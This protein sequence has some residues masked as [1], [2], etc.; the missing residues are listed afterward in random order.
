LIRRYAAEFLGTFAIVFFGCGAIATLSG[1]GSA[2][3]LAINTVFGLTVAAA[4]Y[5]LGHISAAHF[6]PA[7]TI[8]FAVAKRFPW[9]YVPPYLVAQLLGALTGSAIHFALL[10]DKAAN[11]NFGATLPSIDAVRAVGIEALL[12]L[13]L[14]LVIMSVATDRRANGAVPGM[15][16]G[17]VVALCGL[18]GGPLTGCSMNPARSLAPAVFAGSAPLG[19]VWIYVA[20]PILGAVAAALLYEAI[21]GGD[22]HGQGAPN[23]LEIAL[24]KI[25]AQTELM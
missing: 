19:S 22:Q 6:N 8:G 4:I 13:F 10:A 11:V 23:D 20:G 15:A 1:G 18:F 14:M 25:G 7:V 3:H 17:M 12:T 16:I 5:A 2:G 24:E 21:R 9:R